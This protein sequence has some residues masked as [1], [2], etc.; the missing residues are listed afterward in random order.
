MVTRKAFVRPILWHVP[1]FRRRSKTSAT[2]CARRCSVLH[3]KVES[4]VGAQSRAASR[5]NE[6]RAKRAGRTKMTRSLSNTFDVRR[7]NFRCAH[8]AQGIR[9]IRCRR[10][11]IRI[12]R[13]DSRRRVSGGRAM[14][15]GESAEKSRGGCDR[16][17]VRTLEIKAGNAARSDQP[18]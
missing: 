8:R 6:T 16:P 17:C 10:D 4:T 1:Q 3:M 13:C 15:R 9:T 18:K 2:N 11:M 12:A 14:M 7:C 5:R